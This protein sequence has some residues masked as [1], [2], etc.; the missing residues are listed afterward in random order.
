MS[1]DSMRV[2]VFAGTPVFPPIATR[3][4]SQSDSE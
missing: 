4:E 1:R 3:D 2:P